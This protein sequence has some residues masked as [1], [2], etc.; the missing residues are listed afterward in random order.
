MGLTAAQWISMIIL[1]VFP[2]LWHLCY[3]IGKILEKK[4]IPNQA[5]REDLEWIANTAVRQV[6]QI[7]ENSSNAAKKQ[8]AMSIAM[9]FCKVFEVPFLGEEII[10]GAIE[11][12]VFMLP[13]KSPGPPPVGS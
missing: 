11:A 12:A 10:D 8:L 7:S 13:S 9:R 5:I 1:I 6:E 2:V 3:P 4:I